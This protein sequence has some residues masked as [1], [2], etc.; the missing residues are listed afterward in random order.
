MVCDKIRM[1]ALVQ[2]F[3]M[4]IKLWLMRWDGGDCGG[5]TL[6]SP[7]CLYWLIKNKKQ[8]DN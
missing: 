6:L 8:T 4:N 2:P 1:A 7:G 3:A 5:L